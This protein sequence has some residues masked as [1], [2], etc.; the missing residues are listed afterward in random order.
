LK[1]DVGEAVSIPARKDSTEIGPNETFTLHCQAENKSTFIK[2]KDREREAGQV[3]FDHLKMFHSI[4][5][6]S[7]GERDLERTKEDVKRLK[8]AKEEGNLNEMLLDRRAKSK[9]DKFC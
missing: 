2:P 9:S 3:E 5:A 4:Q 8:K 7:F 6:S 1:Y